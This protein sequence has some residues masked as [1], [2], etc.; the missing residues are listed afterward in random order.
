MK[1]RV[2][3]TGGTGFIGTALSTELNAAGYEL[4]V[5][6][7]GEG[8]DGGGIR[9]VRWDARSP[10]G[11]THEVDGAFAVVNLAGDNIGSGRWTAGKKRAIRESRMEA[12][13]AVAA[14]VSA[15]KAKPKVVLQASAIGWYGDRGDERLAEYSARGDGFLPSIARE[16]EDSTAEVEDYGVRRVVV[17]TGVVL[18]RGGMLG[19]AALPFRL[20]AGGIPGGGRPWFSWI[21]LRDAARAIRFLMERKDARGAYNLTSPVPVRAAE[22]YRQLGRTLHRPVWMPLPALALRIAF[23]EMARELVLSGQRVLPER[24]LEAG[25]EFQFPDL[26]QAL[27]EIFGG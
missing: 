8:T 15:A 12:G 26:E 2:V 3:I 14:A 7:R 6:S 9:R 25:F 22:F 20:F 19:R 24:L 10:R 18:G 23:G 13:M 11:W 27:E 1:K 5:L 16:W 21:H 4:V 17:R